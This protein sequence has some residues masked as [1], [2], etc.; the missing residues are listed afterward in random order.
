MEVND[1]HD[2]SQKRGSLE[3]DPAYMES[4]RKFCELL[5]K[6]DEDDEENLP[7]IFRKI[8]GKIDDDLFQEL[9]ERD[10]DRYDEGYDAGAEA[11]KTDDIHSAICAFENIGLS[12]ETML[13][14]LDRF[15]FITPEEGQDIIRDVKAGIH[16]TVISNRLKKE[17][18][19]KTMTQFSNFLERFKKRLL[20][21]DEL[22]YKSSSEV[23]ALLEKE[24]LEQ[25]IE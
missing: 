21:D 10:L 19:I 3:K 20:S 6:Q 2:F 7:D 15:F 18:K 16:V 4:V 23:I 5:D 17:G 9:W 24:G 14:L 1:M 22:A 12:K 8:K 25:F 13:F 11:Q